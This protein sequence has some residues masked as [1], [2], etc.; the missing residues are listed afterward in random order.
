MRRKDAPAIYCALLLVI[1]L[2]TLGGLFTLTADRYIYPLLPA[3]YLMGA[4]AVYMGL[5]TFKKYALS[6]F[7]AES[8]ASPYRSPSTAINLPAGQSGRLQHQASYP[9]SIHL[10]LLF[11]TA[12]LCAGVLISPML[13]ISGYNLFLD[14]QLGFTTHRHFPDYDAVG[15]YM[16]SHWR[17]GDM[18]IAVS[19]AI[20]V[21]YYVRHVDYFF[22]VNRALYLFEKHG[23][24][25]DTPTGS[26]PLLDQRDFEAVLA[27]NKRIW[28]ISDNGEYQAGVTKDGRFTFPSDFHLV[29][30]GYG[31][32]IYFRGG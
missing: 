4:Y 9:L 28:I 24:I 17:R 13:P 3:L 31:S 19:P 21:L 15:Q 10:M 23:R 6:A 7:P 26:T 1:S 20:S 32:A 30:E 22:S 25:T 14:R 29:F 16:Q 11:C 27:A 8:M 18:V 12:L 2:I 5:H